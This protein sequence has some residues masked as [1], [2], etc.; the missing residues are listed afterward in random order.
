MTHGRRQ[1]NQRGSRFSSGS[2]SEDGTWMVGSNTEMMC[3]STSTQ[4]GMKT[5]S[6]NN[7]GSRTITLVLPLPLGP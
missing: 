4:Y 3:P 6:S 2:S 1:R 7:K 5:S